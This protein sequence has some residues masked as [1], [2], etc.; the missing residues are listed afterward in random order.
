MKK[1]VLFG[2]MAVLAAVILISG[3]DK[4][5]GPDEAFTASDQEAMKSQ[6]EGDPLFTSDNM[7]LND[8]DPQTLGK[9]ATPILP[10]AWGRRIT[11]ASRTHTFER[12]SDE[13]VIVTVKHTISGEVKIAAKYTPQDTGVTIISKPFTEETTRKI[14]FVPRQGNV[15]ARWR[16]SEVS[17]VKGGSVNPQAILTFNQMVVYVGPDTLVIND[18]NEYFLK[19]P[20]FI[21][22]QMPTL[23]TGAPITVRLTLT[24]TE[25]DTDFVFLH[26]PF[27]WL[28]A[29]TFRPA[30]ARMTMISQSGSGPYTRT[31]EISWSSHIQGRHHFFVSGITRNSLFDD[32]APWATQLWGVPY[33]VQ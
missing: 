29:S 32:V 13:L 5:T 33:I 3:C 23:G 22:R 8:Q 17:A 6:I 16:P 14:K 2:L 19:L 30:H 15:G 24:S 18:P 4:A 12:I 10:R 26:R 21:G 9:T 25:S 27:M 1:F 20:T 11:S 7:T 31:Y 28:N